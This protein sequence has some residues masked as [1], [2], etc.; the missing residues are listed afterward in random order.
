LSTRATRARRPV[1]LPTGSRAL[2]PTTKTSADQNLGH[3]D[4]ILGRQVS[5]E[6][7]D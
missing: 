1:S 6:C 7:S 3:I 5:N 4:N 2:P